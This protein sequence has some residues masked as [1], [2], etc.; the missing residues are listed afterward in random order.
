MCEKSEQI[1]KA[2]PGPWKRGSCD[3]WIIWAPRYASTGWVPQGAS[4]GDP[5]T[6]VVAAVESQAWAMDGLAPDERDA[7]LAETDATA[8]LISAAPDMLEVLKAAA[9]LV[10]SDVYDGGRAATV[11]AQINAALAKAEGR[12]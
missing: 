10:A 12:S 1:C 2:T 4:S 11:L 8:N 5:E 6:V 3:S 7:W 9:D